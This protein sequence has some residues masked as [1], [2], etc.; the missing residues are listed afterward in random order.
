ML[1]LAEM[2]SSTLFWARRILS[3][4][5]ESYESEQTHD[6]TEKKM[7]VTKHITKANHGIRYA[8]CKM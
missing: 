5:H 6:A 2:F 4:D 8:Y 7:P 1:L 3:E